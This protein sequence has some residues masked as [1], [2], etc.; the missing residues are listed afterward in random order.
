MVIKRAT[1][2]ASTVVVSAEEARSTMVTALV[3]HGATQSDADFQADTLLEGDLRGHPSHGI[4]RLPVLVGRL[5][6]GLIVSGTPAT[7]EWLTDSALS[8]DGKRGFGTVV[9]RDAVDEIV[10]RAASTGIAIATIRNANHVGMLAPYVERMTARGCIGLAFT[11]SE[12]LVH[13]WGGMSAMVGTNPI[14]IGVP[15]LGDPLVLDM[16]TGSTSAGKIIDYAARGQEIPP[17]WAV[18]AAGVPTTDATAALDG[19]ISP[20]GGAKGYALGLAIEVLV[21]ALTGSA[22]GRDVL[23]TLD[24]ENVSSKGDVF[25]A[26]S[27]DRLGGSASLSTVTSYLAAVRSSGAGDGSVSAPGDRARVTRQERL[28]NGMPIDQDLWTRVL[29]LSIGDPS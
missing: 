6:A 17:G 23:G 14:G 7:H 28:D 1:A 18:D 26:I 9:S 16:S 27:L 29:E 15:T 24:T 22:L 3:A 11:I 13:P 4:R 12:A 8:V 5:R 21:G 2:S 19:A 25:I 10:A 20:F